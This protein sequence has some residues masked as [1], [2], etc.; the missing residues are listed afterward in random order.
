MLE[1]SYVPHESLVILVLAFVE[2]HRAARHVFLL[3]VLV[4]L[5]QLVHLDAVVLVLLTVDISLL[6]EVEEYLVVDIYILDLRVEVAEDFPIFLDN[7]LVG[8]H[9]VFDSLEEVAKV[10]AVIVD[11]VHSLTHFLC[12]QH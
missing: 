5:A 8:Y 6:R 4:F 7:L 11:S 12:L 10:T 2:D 9:V 1:F 3:S